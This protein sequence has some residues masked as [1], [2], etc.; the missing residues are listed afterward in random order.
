MRAHHQR[1]LAGGDG[2]QH[3]AALLLLLAAGEPG[4]ALAARRQQRRQPA[5]QLGEVL[6]GQDLG[7]CHQ[8][9][10]PAGLDGHAGGQRGHHGLAAAHVALQQAVH[11]LLARQVAGDLL[12]HAAL[13]LGELEGQRGQQLLGQATRRRAQ[14]RGAQV[15]ARA[16]SLQLR[17][18][19]RQQLLGLQ[20]QPGR[21]AAVFQFGE[22]RIRQRL[23]QER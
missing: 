18:L 14:H 1:G 10:L 19:L 4:H 16:P 5:D 22:H 13:G 3:L 11:G 17:Q 8:R 15:L 20:P 12:G 7:G 21:V 2:G 6:L 23:V 9:A